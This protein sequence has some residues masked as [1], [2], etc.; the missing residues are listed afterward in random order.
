MDPSVT[1]HVSEGRDTGYPGLGGLPTEQTQH[2]TWAPI[3]W[4]PPPDS[5]RRM[6]ILGC[7]LN[8]RHSVI[9]EHPA[10]LR[11]WVSFLLTPFVPQ[12]CIYLTFSFVCIHLSSETL[13]A[14]VFYGQGFK[15]NNL[16]L[17]ISGLKMC[18]LNKALLMVRRACTAR[19]WV[20]VWRLCPGSNIHM[21]KN[22][23]NS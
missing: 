11:I 7:S 20:E 17:F 12:L 5:R 15:D 6:A 3:H 13:T 10:H 2:P 16:T 19:R 23:K 1:K 18:F 8:S 22:I 9:Q 4:A 14:V 21:C